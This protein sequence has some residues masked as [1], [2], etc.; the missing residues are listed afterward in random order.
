MADVRRDNVYQQ[1]STVMRDG[2]D[3]AKPSKS[4]RNMEKKRAFAKSVTTE[5]RVESSA[6]E[7][8]ERSK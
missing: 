7:N 5:R 1:M 8:G 2:S 6:D 4:E 3:V